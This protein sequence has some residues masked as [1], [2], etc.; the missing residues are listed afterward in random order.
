MENAQPPRPRSPGT[1]ASRVLC[2]AA[3]LAASGALASA[4][5][6]AAESVC[7]GRGTPLSAAPADGYT[8]ERFAGSP[9]EEGRSRSGT[10]VLP[11]DEPATPP[12]CRGCPVPG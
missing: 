9:V 1:G 12:R 10:R 4:F 11:R 5:V 6:V 7:I 8:A 2:F 3:V